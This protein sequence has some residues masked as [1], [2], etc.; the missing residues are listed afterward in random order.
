M[1]GGQRI[2]ATMRTIAAKPKVTA[3][4]GVNRRA[5]EKWGRARASPKQAE[6]RADDIAPINH[7]LL[8][9]AT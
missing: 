9:V 7:K 8:T 6:S 4:A 5:A 1:T 3:W 2:V